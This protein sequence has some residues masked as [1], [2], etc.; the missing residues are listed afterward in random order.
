[1]SDSLDTLFGWH[2]SNPRKVGKQVKDNGDIEI[3]NDFCEKCIHG[4]LGPKKLKQRY[5]F[6]EIGFSLAQFF[7]GQAVVG[8]K[9]FPE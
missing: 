5:N 3:L 1:M 6:P 4:G 9:C 2:A 7:P 8:A